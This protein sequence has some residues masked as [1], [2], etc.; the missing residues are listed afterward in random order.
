MLHTTPL[1]TVS[2]SFILSH[3]NLGTHDDHDAITRAIQDISLTGGTVFLPPGAY[4]V[5][6]PLVLSW[7][8]G[9]TIRGA[10]VVP[11]SDPVV[12]E[13]I[14]LFLLFNVISL[15]FIFFAYS[16]ILNPDRWH[17]DYFQQHGCLAHY[18]MLPYR[19]FEHSVHRRGTRSFRRRECLRREIVLGYCPGCANRTRVRSE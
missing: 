2:I 11:T 9:V 17:A 1:E 16:L 3:H 13:V 12:R 14:K 19:G 6:A 4:L 10:G 7:A 5:G 8:S 15:E 18:F